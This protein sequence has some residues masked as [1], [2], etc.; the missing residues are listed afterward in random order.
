MQNKKKIIINYIKK[1][2]KKYGCFS[3]G[4]IDGIDWLPPVNE[5]GKLVALAEVFH[6]NYVEVNI[7]NPNS[8]SSDPIEDPYYLPYEKLSLELLVKIEELC[9][10]WEAINWET[11]KTISK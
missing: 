5:M 7:Y 3:I 8:H 4:E 2:I 6:E 1:L 9:D 10:C 11:E